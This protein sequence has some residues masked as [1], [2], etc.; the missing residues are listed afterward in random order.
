MFTHCRLIPKLQMCSAK[1]NVVMALP[2][3]HPL[4]PKILYDPSLLHFSQNSF[5]WNCFSCISVRTIPA[6][7]RSEIEESSNSSIK[8][9]SGVENPSLLTLF[10]ERPWKSWNA[11]SKTPSM[12]T[13]LQNQTLKCFPSVYILYYTLYWVR[14]VKLSYTDF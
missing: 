5:S 7:P 8:N 1:T 12:K 14:T 13:Q 10:L 2:C 11:R 6:Q 4:Y 3:A 9:H